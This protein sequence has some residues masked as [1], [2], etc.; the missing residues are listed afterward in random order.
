MPASVVA[1]T[2]F[3]Q[4][5]RAA[6]TLA[7]KVTASKF[8]HRK[9]RAVEVATGEGEGEGWERTH[10]SQRVNNWH[11]YYLRTQGFL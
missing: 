4:P 10:Q 8:L 7:V 11:S 2:I 5:V 1:F 6:L 9:G 3:C